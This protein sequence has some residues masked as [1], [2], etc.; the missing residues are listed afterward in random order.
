M[1]F[2]SM[3]KALTTPAGPLVVPPGQL[4][5]SV[6]DAVEQ[7]VAAEV[8]DGKRAAVLAVYDPFTRTASVQVAAKIGDS[9]KLAANVDQTW[10]GPVTGQ[11]ML[12]GS[13]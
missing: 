3:Q 12:V 4:D 8:P 1:S 2:A 6:K 7:A 5:Q 9:W 11:V 10:G 13:F